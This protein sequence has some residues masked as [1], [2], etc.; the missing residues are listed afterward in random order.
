M[1]PI[2]TLL[3]QRMTYQQIDEGLFDITSIKAIGQI[4]GL[5]PDEII[6]VVKFFTELINKKNA[7]LSFNANELS[8][9]DEKL[10]S[11]FMGGLNSVRMAQRVTS[12]HR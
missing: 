4:I 9:E 3:Q 11:S 6:R 5:K 10:L 2:M 7:G 12:Q 8:P 1:N